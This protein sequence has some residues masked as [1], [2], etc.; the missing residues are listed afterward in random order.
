MLVTGQACDTE[1]AGPAV[2]QITVDVT[3]TGVNI[4][5]FLFSVNLEH[6]RYAMWKLHLRGI[7]AKIV[8]AGVIHVGNEIKK[9]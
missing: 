6:T 5:P 8:Q 3:D 1:A 4:S 9:L 2:E 7:Y